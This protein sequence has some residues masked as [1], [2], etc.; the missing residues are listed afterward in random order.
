MAAIICEFKPDLIHINYI[1]FPNLNA[2]ALKQALRD[3]PWLLTFHCISP[4]EKHLDT[5]HSS[6]A[7]HYFLR[8]TIFIGHT[9]LANWIIRHASFR[10]AI[11]HSRF[12]ADILT[13]RGLG[14]DHTR[15]I[16]LGIDS[17]P[18]AALTMEPI[19][20]T[21]RNNL[22]ITT[23]AGL[24]HTKGQLDMIK[25]MPAVLTNYPDAHYHIIGNIRAPNYHK[26][27]IREIDRLGLSEHIS[28]HM[29]VSDDQKRSMLAATD[30]YIQPSH[31][32]GFCLAFLEAALQ[33]PIVIGARTGAMREIAEGRTG[34][35]TVATMD[36]KALYQ[37]IIAGAN[38]HITDEQLKERRE[39]LL[40]EFSV[41]QYGSK[42]IELYTET[43]ARSQDAGHS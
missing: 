27:L 30:I 2:P 10:N 34:M 12:V 36:S 39:G 6:N 35:M 26:H 11:V 28:I 42:H 23:V 20:K 43:L 5:A 38:T 13:E 37:A 15:L 33:V 8:N 31:E 7:L 17:G 24:S 29:G 25:A 16:H 14:T 9:I 22:T 4:Y 41:A 1:N 21:H 19:S 3:I 40:H 32:E 18:A